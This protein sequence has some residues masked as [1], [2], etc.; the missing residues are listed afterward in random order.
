VKVGDE[1]VEYSAEAAAAI[2]DASPMVEGRDAV[3]LAIELD[4]TSEADGVYPIVLV[5]YL[6]ACSE[7]EDAERAE[8]TKSYLAY[9][10]SDEGQ[11]ASAE[12]AGTAP[13]SVSLFEK[14]QRR[15]RQRSSK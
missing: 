10:I 3:D 2:V 4:R 14:A 6:I 5:S 12:A 13:I 9:I 7:Y 15:G 1:Y 8:L 11:A